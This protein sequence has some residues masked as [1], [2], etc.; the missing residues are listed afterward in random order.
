ML[1]LFLLAIGYFVFSIGLE[2]AHGGIMLVGLG[3]HLIAIAALIKEFGW[4]YFGVLSLV[5]IC[6]L[7]LAKKSNQSV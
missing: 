4:I 3:I 2:V 7:V 5:G 1:I 6:V